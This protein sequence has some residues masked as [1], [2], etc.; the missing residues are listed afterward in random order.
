MDKSTYAKGGGVA[1]NI[2]ERTMGEGG[3]QISAIFVCMYQLNNSRQLYEKPSCA[4]KNF[5][6]PCHWQAIQKATTTT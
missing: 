6:K 1:G 5:K 2:N 4:I 3:G